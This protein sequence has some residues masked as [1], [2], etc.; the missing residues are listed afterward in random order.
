MFY[1]E[2]RGEFD[3]SEVLKSKKPGSAF[4]LA[5]FAIVVLSL[6][7]TGLL[8][9]GLQSRIF[10]IRTA[11]EIKA[12]CAADAGLTRALY[13]MNQKLVVKPWFDS[14]LPEATDLALPNCDLVFS[15]TVIVDDSDD[16]DDYDGDDDGSSCYIIE[17]TGR[18]GQAVK[19][20]RGVLALRGP[21]NAAMAVRNNIVLKPNSVIDGYNYTKEGEKLQLATLSTLPMQIILGKSSLVDGD[22][23][24]GFGG[25]PEQ[26]ICGPQ[27]TITGQQYALS[28]DIEF[29]TITVPDW[30]GGMPL[31]GTISNPTTISSSGR[32]SGVNI[33]QG[34]IVTIDGP[35][36]LYVEGDISLS[37]SAQLQIADDDDAYLTLYLG[38]NLY[39]KNGGSVNNI[40]Q[41]PSKLKIYGLDTCTNLSFATAGAFYGAICTPNAM[42]NMKSSVEIYGSLLADNFNQGQAANFHYDASLKSVGANDEGVHFVITKWSEL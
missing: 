4:L 16:D 31:Q 29:P 26:V 13:E 2:K 40:T 8:R 20:V 28:E 38:G 19:T 7:G 15:F 37:N 3:M 23:A 11:D 10:A 14:V 25:D 17:S 22:V 33:A 41:T 42:L 36:T 24:V 12:R 9:L 18:A 21:F 35:V 27:A 30:L 1:H 32:Y 39:C 6:M 34:E 5:L